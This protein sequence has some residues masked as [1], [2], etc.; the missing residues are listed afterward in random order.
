VTGGT[1]RSGSRVLSFAISLVDDRDAI[2]DLFARYCLLMDQGLVDKWADLYTEDGQF[3]QEGSEP[4][5]GT[6]ALRAFMAA[7][8][9][10]V[11]HH[12]LVNHAIDVSD[13]HATSIAS[14][15]VIS[16]G[17]IVASGRA[18]D[19]LRRLDG[20]W[21]IRRRTFTPDSR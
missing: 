17:A 9:V 1:G 18:R 21:R 16:K 5:T 20:R 8:S 2:R 6:E 19:E 10:G 12:I 11:I 7:Q 14:V 13:D 15:I 3:V 4:I